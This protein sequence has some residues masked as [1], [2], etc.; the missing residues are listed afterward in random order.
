MDAKEDDIG[1]MLGVATATA[2]AKDVADTADAVRREKREGMPPEWDAA[3]A[4]TGAEYGEWLATLTLQEYA[5]ARR[6]S[7]RCFFNKGL[8]PGSPEERIELLKQHAEMQ[9][10]KGGTKGGD[11]GDITPQVAAVAMTGHEYH[12]GEAA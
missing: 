5:E 10:Q 7:S 4:T 8:V 2:D 12:E 9:E 3:G 11:A 1:A 6:N